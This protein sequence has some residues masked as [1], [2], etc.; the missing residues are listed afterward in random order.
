MHRG[1]APDALSGIDASSDALLR[2]V[3]SI[4]VVVV[5]PVAGI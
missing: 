4:R 2:S 1:R 5:P 3:S